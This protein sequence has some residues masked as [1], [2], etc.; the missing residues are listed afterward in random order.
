MHI[1][2]RRKFAGI[3]AGMLFG[4]AG[5]RAQD[6]YPNRAVKFVVPFPPGGTTDILGRV[7][8]QKMSNIW[9]QPVIV[10]NRAGA[11]GIVG[12]EFV[13]RAPAD[14]YTLVLGTIGTHG[15]S[16]S[17]VKNLPYQPERDFAPVTLL[18]TLPNVLVVNLDVPAKS[19]S[20]LIA[21]AKQNPGKLSY[22][23]AGQGTASHIAGEYFKRVAG[24]DVVHVPYKGSAPALS[25]I[26][27]G[28][29]AYAF[30]YMPASMPFISSGK[31][32]ALATTGIKRSHV[33]PNIPTAIEQGLELNILTWF[34]VYAPTGTPKPILQQIRDTLA[35]A[36]ADPEVQKRMD[37][38]GVDLVVDTPNELA[39]FQHAEIKRWSQFIAEAHISAE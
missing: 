8:A 26:M 16:T 34:A 2:D 35:K 12:S 28:H 21:Y 24:V 23:S 33:T 25:D 19:L 13:A 30:D 29:V 22:A 15:M 37:P 6:V 31:L 9:D 32:R 5:V 3:G 18:A 20:E 1:M 4:A 27:A 11:G 39:A 10:E 14:G 38:L 36:A 17:L 7:F